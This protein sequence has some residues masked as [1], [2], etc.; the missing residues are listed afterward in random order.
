MES[1]ASTH[2]LSG[3]DGSLAK[4]L[5]GESSGIWVE[6]ELYLSVAERVLL[7]HAGSLG[8]SITLWCVEC[9]LNFGRVN[10]AGKVSVGDNVGW[11][12]EILLGGG[13]GGGGAVDFIEGS[14]GG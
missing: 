10:Q 5:L 6:A 8:L 14:K 1:L 2:G 12:E 3:V 4:L 7:L 13:W 11:E 9:G